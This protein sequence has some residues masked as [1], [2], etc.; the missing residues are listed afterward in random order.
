MLFP[1]VA[2]TL[3][4]IVYL[5]VSVLAIYAF[6]SVL[7]EHSNVLDV[8]SATD[9]TE[10][11]VLRIFYMVIAA[12]HIP[13][14]FCPGKDAGL[15]IL[16]ELLYNSISAVRETDQ[17]QKQRCNVIWSISQRWCNSN[18]KILYPMKTLM[19]CLKWHYFRTL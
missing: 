5:L 3:T 18:R 16:A 17:S 13:F 9:T 10:S 7:R 8:I 11:F 19:I 12:T 4:Q 6:G 2:L 1:A 14:I 15:V